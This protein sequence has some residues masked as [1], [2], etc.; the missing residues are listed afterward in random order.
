MC[1]D[2]DER[3]VGPIRDFVRSPNASSIDGVRVRLFDAYMTALDNVPFQ[4]GMRLTNFRKFFGPE[5]REILML[6]KNSDF[7]E[8]LGLDAREPKVDGEIR[9]LFLCQHYGKSLSSDHWEE[10]CEYYSEHFPYESYGKKWAERKGRALH[11]QSD[12]GRQLYP[13][14]AELFENSVEI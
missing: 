1:C 3:Y 2:A 4:K 11:L 10:T 7:V 12:F 9:S 5:F 13:W 8:F 14:G 6:W